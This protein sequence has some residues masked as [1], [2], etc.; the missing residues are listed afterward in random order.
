MNGR[1]NEKKETFLVSYI[2]SLCLEYPV[3]FSS[4]PLFFSFLFALDDVIE[5][6]C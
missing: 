6:Q 2:P 1:T 4:L 5:I 3:M